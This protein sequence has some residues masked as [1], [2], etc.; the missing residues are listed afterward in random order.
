MILSQNSKTTARV[1]KHSGEIIP[2][3]ESC[4]FQLL[5]DSLTKLASP[6]F[7]FPLLLRNLAR[8]AGSESR[9]GLE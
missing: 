6:P 5:N 7:F 2:Y 8:V 9:S 4:R 1:N 3:V